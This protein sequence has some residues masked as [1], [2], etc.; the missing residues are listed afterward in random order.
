VRVLLVHN[1]Y[2]QPGGEDVVF[3]LERWLLE[4]RGHQ[5]IVYRR[6]NQEIDAYGGVRRIGLVKTAIW[7]SDSRQDFA[8]LLRREKPDVVHVHNTFV[9]ISPSIYSACYEAG[10]P[11][12]QTLHNYR[13]LCPGATF[14]RDGKICEDC[15]DRSLWQSVRH[16]CYRD[17]RSATAIVALMLAI[18]RQRNTWGREISRFVALSKFSR[19]K[20]IEG[21]VP[22]EKISVKPNFI[23]PDPG[24][25]SGN[26]EYGLF[27]GRL[28]PEK[29][30]ST[31]LMA[32]KRFRLDIPIFIIGGGPDRDEL[33]AQ[34]ATNGLANVHFL[35]YLPREQA[36]AY[37][38]K[39]RFLIFSS[40]W[41]ENCPMTLVEAFACSVP[42]ICS[43]IG[44]MQEMV[45]NGR[46]G[47]FFAPGDPDDLAEKVVWAW[48]HPH[49]M[50]AM[51]NEARMEY[52][53]TY[54]AEKNYAMLMEIY[55]SVTEV[56][57]Q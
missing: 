2:Q 33:E 44:S 12:V 11:L 20:F 54:T 29:R 34:S 10:I 26:G 13:L 28:S 22:A 42:V 5:V 23:H 37:L 45:A 7:A 4:S 49:E 46:T 38:R 32:W 25:R 50:R 18:H 35:G 55:R 57:V 8:Q 51:G 30:V 52:E 43:A 1:T 15:L 48:N 21:G 47:L 41:Y 24:V 31:L 14:F 6:S 9:M 3:E 40:E 16:A 36:L 56:P 53:S 39:A 17:S 27:V 19:T